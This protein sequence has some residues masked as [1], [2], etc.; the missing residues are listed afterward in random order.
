[1]YK[2]ERFAVAGNEDGI[3]LVV[4]LGAMSRVGQ[5]KHAVL[6]RVAVALTP[7]AFDRS[8][9]RV[10]AQDLSEK[11]GNGGSPWKD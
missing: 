7:G 1:M 11:A 10:G 4:T 5:H 3:V 8:G 2:L 9:D 6:A